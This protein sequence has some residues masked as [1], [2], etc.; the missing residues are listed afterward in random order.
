MDKKPL[1]E[2]QLRAIRTMGN[3]QAGGYLSDLIEMELQSCINGMLTCSVTDVADMAYGQA[4]A[5]ICK[6]F[7]GILND[8]IDQILEEHNIEPEEN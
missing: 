2:A 3:T 5:G 4:G 8:D 7:F 1:N 6:K